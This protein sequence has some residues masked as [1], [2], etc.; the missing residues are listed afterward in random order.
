VTNTGT[1]ALPVMKE[2]EQEVKAGK[3]NQIAGASNHPGD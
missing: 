3:E 2:V 1:G